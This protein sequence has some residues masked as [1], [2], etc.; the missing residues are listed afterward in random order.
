MFL[1]VHSGLLMTTPTDVYD[2]SNE[3]LDCVM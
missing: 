2:N 3:L 1:F